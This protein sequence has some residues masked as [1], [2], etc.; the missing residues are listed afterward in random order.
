MPRSKRT[1]NM[2]ED[3]IERIVELKLDRVPVRQIAADVG[4]DKATVQ[5]H[6]SR[7]V[8][9]TRPERREPLEQKRAE[10]IA[11]LDSV[12]TMARR[13]AVR[14][15]TGGMDE[16]DAARAE[17]KFLAEERQ[18]LRMLSQ[19]AGYDAPIRVQASFDTMTEAEA[20]AILDE[21]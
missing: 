18:A 19:V 4:C 8:E 5:L 20:K 17:A 2:T 16:A 3:E 6:W 12:A 10:V 13:G 9:D 1:Q 21:L 11:R 15:R 7:W 14:A